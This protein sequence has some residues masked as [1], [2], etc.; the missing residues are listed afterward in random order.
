MMEAYL[1]GDPY[2][3]FAKQAGA[4]PE[5][6]TK[7]SHKRERDIFKTVVLG[8][9]YGM[10]AEAL[11]GRIG[12][13][14]LEARE[15]LQ[16]HRETYPKFWR[17]AQN[18]VDGAVCNLSLSSVFG[19]RLRMKAE[20]NPRSIRNF[21]MQ[22]NG[23]EM[24]RIACC[25]GTERGVQVCAPVHDALL[26]EASVDEIDAEIARMQSYMRAA[27]RVVLDGFELRTDAE[28]VRYPNRYSD[29]RGT[30]MW[31]RV[32]RLVTQAG[33]RHVSNVR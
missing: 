6:A 28:I 9:G 27:S 13:S 14:V 33:G 1:S 31:E 24:L 19:W 11:A 18:I 7:A 25:L 30:V 16:K 32:M 10:E 5:D 2:L 26:I 17:W 3:A 29:P 23:S 8:V 20:A 12:V 4:I 22:A 15:L 21:P